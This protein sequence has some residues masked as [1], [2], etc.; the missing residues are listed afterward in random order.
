MTITSS[1]IEGM[2]KVLKD[3]LMTSQGDLLHVVGRIE[4]MVQCQYNKYRKEIASA[5]HSLKFKHSLEAMPFLPPRIHKVITPPAIDHI[6]EQD[7]LRQKET[8][9]RQGGYSCSGLVQ[10]TNGLPCH[11]IIQIIIL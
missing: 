8:K 3:Y 4:Q 2:H 1:P 11:H 5:K 6:R 9:P 10:K 7:L